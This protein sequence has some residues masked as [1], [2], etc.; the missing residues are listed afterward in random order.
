MVSRSLG[1]GQALDGAAQHVAVGLLVEVFAPDGPG[2]ALA[3]LGPEDFAQVRGDLVVGVALQRLAQV[4]LGVG[5]LALAIVDPA[6]AVEDRRVV[7]VQLVR[8]ED[9]LAGLAVAGGAVGQ[10]VAEGVEGHGVVRL[11]GDDEAQVLFHLRQSLRFS[12][13]I[14]RV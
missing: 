7:R 12:A 2:V 10:G 1:A 9:Q 13:S 4:A 14:E 11:A 5:Q 8:L 3:P 6:H